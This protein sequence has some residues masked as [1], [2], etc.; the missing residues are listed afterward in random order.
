MGH[1]GETFSGGERQRIAIACALLRRPTVLLLHEATSQLDAANESSIRRVVAHMGTRAAVVIV[2]HGLSTVVDA[3]QIVLM[4]NGRVRNIGTHTTLL[5]T[6]RPYRGMVDE[7]SLEAV[8]SL[9]SPAAHR[10]RPR[11]RPAD[12]RDRGRPHRPRSA[13]NA[14]SSRRALI[15]LRNRPASAPSTRRWS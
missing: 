2:A 10:R 4:E 1:R 15:A 14:P 6:D 9:G 11:P 7:Q 3:D 12:A 8:S 5:R 13:S